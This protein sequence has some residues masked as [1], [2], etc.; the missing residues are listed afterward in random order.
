MNNNRVSN[1]LKEPDQFQQESDIM[2]NDGLKV[3]ERD[4]LNLI[5]DTLNPKDLFK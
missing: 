4:Q 1:K 2:S 3:I 5:Y